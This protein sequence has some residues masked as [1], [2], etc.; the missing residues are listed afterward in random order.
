MYKDKL[1][2]Y[3]YVGSGD[4]KKNSADIPGDAIV[5]VSSE[6]VLADWLERNSDNVD[7]DGLVRATFIISKDFELIIAERNYEHVACAGGKTVLSAGEIGFDPD[8][9]SIETISNQSTGYCPEAK[10]WGAV[11]IALNNAGLIH[12]EDFTDKFEFRKC[13]NEKCGQKK[14]IN[15]D[16]LYECLMCGSPLPKDWNF[17]D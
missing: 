9:H 17:G 7:I 10:S 12:P 2:Q 15:V 16:G 11:E 13:P 3:N 6:A 14:N 1:K 4:I 5:I 8:N